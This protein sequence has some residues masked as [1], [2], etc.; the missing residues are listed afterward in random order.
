MKIKKILM[1]VLYIQ[2]VSVFISGYLSKKELRDNKNWSNINQVDLVTERDDMV[3]DE[4]L[5][6]DFELNKQDIDKKIERSPDQLRNKTTFITYQNVPTANIE[7]IEF[8]LF[9]SK[10]RRSDPRDNYYD[11]QYPEQ[12]P[13]PDR[14]PVRPGP[15]RAKQI[16]V[17]K[18]LEFLDA[19]NRNDTFKVGSMLTDKEFFGNTFEQAININCQ[20]QD[21][22]WSALMIAAYNNYSQMVD[23]LLD[24]K[25]NKSLIHDS[26]ATAL[27]FAF[28]KNAEQA[29]ELLLKAKASPFEGYNGRTA[30]E[31]ARKQNNSTMIGL[32]RWHGFQI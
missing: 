25:A 11:P 5:R 14:R 32:L 16:C 4:V 8:W 2:L 10:P 1:L 27:S 24:Y 31:E 17:G 19:V 26:G 13:R 21:G 22:G 29:A 30:I 20:K 18:D 6:E 15:I 28:E 23:L 12:R 3:F 7:L 9:P